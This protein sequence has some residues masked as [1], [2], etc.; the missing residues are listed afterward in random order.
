MKL[1]VIVGM[2][3]FVPVCSHAQSIKACEDLKTEIAAKLDAKGAKSYTL[4]IVAKDKG[5]EGKVVG[6]CEGG[7]KKIVYSKTSTAPE[8]SKH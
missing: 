2:L 8:A 6:A 3:L 4:E 1:L 5:S 7:A